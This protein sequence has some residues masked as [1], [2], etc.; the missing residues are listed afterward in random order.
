MTTLEFI[1]YMVTFWFICATVIIIYVPSYADVKAK[2]TFK[3]RDKFSV[4]HIFMY[5]VTT[6]M[7]IIST[8]ITIK[9]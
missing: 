4:L 8:L 7:I 9:L 2:L 6:I 5:F 3:E 1:N